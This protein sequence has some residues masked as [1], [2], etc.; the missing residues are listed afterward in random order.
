MTMAESPQTNLNFSDRRAC[1]S[2]GESD[3]NATIV[4][5]GWVY[6]YRDQ[7]GVLFVDLR[8]RSG[9]VQVVFDMAA[10]AELLKKA[11]SLRS[12]DVIYVTG[13]VRLRDKNAIN[14]KLKTGTVEILA[15]SLTLLS[16]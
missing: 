8:D 16:K 6:R 4:V 1:N 9:V 7:G 2:V 15:T 5:C 10:D 13:K 3:N 12:E 11:D 14:P